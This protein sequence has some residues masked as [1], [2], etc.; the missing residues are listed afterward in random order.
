[1]DYVPRGA[2]ES[3]A[4]FAP[5]TQRAQSSILPYAL[6]LLAAF[7]FT[8]AAFVWIADYAPARPAA[9]L[10]WDEAGVVTFQGR[11]I[12]RWKW[13]GGSWVVSPDPP[14]PRG[15]ALP[16]AGPAHLR[17]AVFTPCV[18]PNRCGRSA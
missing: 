5:P 11:S 16:R 2:T 17:L 18:W 12:G 3:P 15:G 8:V 13:G 7:I 10:C 9:E 6:P 1:M 14:G 4:E